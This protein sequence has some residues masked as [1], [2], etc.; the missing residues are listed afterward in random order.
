MRTIGTVALVALVTLVTFTLGGVSSALADPIVLAIEG[1][2]IYIGLGARDGVGA[3][4]E[5]ELLH[6]V[7]ARDPRTGA[8]LH[9]RFALGTIV[10]EKSGA[11]VS[12]ARADEALVKRVLV[13]DAV[14]LVSAKRTFADP[15]A[16]QVATS[17]GEVEPPVAP[18]VVGPAIPS[19]PTPAI[20]HAG[21]ALAAWKAT[22][23]QPIDQ[24]IARWTELQRTD[25][26]SPY[27]AAVDAEITSLRRQAAQRVEAIAR[28]SATAAA[29]P[30]RDPHLLDLIHALDIPERDAELIV[31]PLERAVPG[32]AI[33]LAF[34]A[35]N[36]AA[37][38]ALFVRPAGESGFR[39]SELRRDGDA[40][41]RGTIEASQVHVGA[42]AYY[43][44]VGDREV[45][46]T[47]DNPRTIT[48][49]PTVAEAPV[50]LHRTH[51]DAHVDYVDFDGKFDKG[52][53]QYTQAELDFTYRFLEPIYAF[54]LGFGTLTGTGGPK[55]VIDLDPT[56]C[57]D[58]ITHT[59]RCRRVTFSYIYTELEFRLRKTVAL[60]LRPQVGLLT[61]DTMNSGN[62]RCKTSKDIGG[63]AF[64]TPFGLR[65]RVR[66]GEED[67]TNLVL[68][69]GIT[70]DVG[71]LLEVAYNWRPH[72]VVPVQLSVQVTDQ[73]VVENFGV[74]IIADVGIRQL[75]WFYPSVR[76]SY[77]AR[78]IDHTG[79]SGGLALNFDW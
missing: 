24:R 30:G 65:A 69:V 20:D 11:S 40:Y 17:K 55:D 68:G 42:L 19:V 10:V 79:F 3:G 12:I 23:G 43:V 14:R 51:I 9:D 18:L 77:Q 57:I 54:R 35:R 52:Y 44:V 48:V 4:S 47:A 22:V 38:A 16:E 50:E 78:D 32:R 45:I 39:R 31:A 59:Y 15:W 27:H 71:T 26:R 1:H 76:V 46:G 36:L 34:I 49:E 28:A 29:R 64:E 75:A 66:L 6:Q 5:L 41:V 61:T 8:T 73:P 70:R 56:G 33:E 7:V 2:D 72:P 25:P 60:L 13:G 21:L 74:R 53:D 63:C 37:P 58:T 62:D 67:S